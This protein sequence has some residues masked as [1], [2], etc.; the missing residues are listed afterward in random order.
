MKN[1]FN[2]LISRPDM[3]EERI[4]ELE[5]MPIKTPKTEKQRENMKTRE[6]WDNYKNCNICVMG[7]PEGE[8]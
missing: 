1:A 8:E 3:T 5:Y 2:G 4:S 7:T 6:L